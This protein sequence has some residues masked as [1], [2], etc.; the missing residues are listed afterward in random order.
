ML[1]HY[2]DALAILKDISTS[3][4]DPMIE[5]P[6][7][8]TPSQA[9]SD[10][11]IHREQGDWAEAILTCGLEDIVGNEYDIVKYGKSDKIIAGQEGFKD[12][13]A[14][15]QYE[16][17]AIGKRP[18]ILILPK[19]IS[20]TKDLS[21]MNSDNSSKYVK[22]A[23]L[24]IEIRSSA[25]LFKKYTAKN[26]EN[27][28][29]FLSFTPKVEDINVVLKW[30]KTYNVPHYYAQVFFDEVHIIS[31]KKILET[32]RDHNKDKTIYSIKKDTRNQLK[33]TFHIN[34]SQGIKIAD[35][36]IPPEHQSVRTELSSG[37][38][39]HYVSFQKGVIKVNHDKL[40]EVIVESK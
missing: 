16:L 38:L 29:K 17:S 37:R 31:F 4:I 25:F 24:G 28:K 7:P 14:Q 15:Y 21:Q 30:I 23:I 40:K 5:R 27:K 33:S 2:S 26:I 34:I 3:T 10:F 11:V 39:L 35:I 1:S 19:E 6:I 22:D 9:F 13:Y 20:P 18:D 36:D 32:I 8:R 12:F